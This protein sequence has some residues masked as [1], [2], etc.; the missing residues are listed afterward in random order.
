[1][2]HLVSVSLYFPLMWNGSL[3]SVLHDLEIWENHRSSGVEC[4]SNW[5]CLIF[6]HDHAQ[7]MH[8][9]QEYLGSDIV[10][11]SQQ[12]IRKK[13]VPVFLTSGD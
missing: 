13:M 2:L 6:P 10:S 11:F 3:A 5:A 12:S 1:M 4:F 9:L 7:V 8:F